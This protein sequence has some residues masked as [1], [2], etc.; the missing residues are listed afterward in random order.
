MNFLIANFQ[1]HTSKKCGDLYYKGNCIRTSNQVLKVRKSADWRNFNTY[2][3]QLDAENIELPVS[4]AD[5]YF[6]LDYNCET[7]ILIY[8]TDMIGF[9]A[10]FYYISNKIFVLSDDVFELIKCLKQGLG[11]D[12]SLNLEKVKELL[13]YTT[14]FFGTTIFSDICRSKP[15]TIVTL[16]VR[17]LKY[18]EKSYDCF[19]MTGDY[20]NPKDAAKGIFHAIDKYFRTHY[21]QGTKYAIGM[22]GGLDSRV[23]AYFAVK[24]GFDLQPIFIGRKHN[25]FGMMT[26]DCKRA[27]EVNGH[28]S[29]GP[30]SYY[31][32]RKIS[33][34]NKIMFEAE[35]APTVQDNIA[36]N[37]G[38]LKGIE[39]L[40]NALIGGEAMGAL[41]D[42]TLYHMDN[43]QLASYM[44]GK[45]T[46]IPK[47]KS[48][49]WRRIGQIFPERVVKKIAGFKEEW[50]HEIL[51]EEYH[52]KLID[53]IIIWIHEQKAL[54]LDN[55]N[56]F[57][58]YFYYNLGSG[59]KYSYYA[60]FNNTNPALFTYLNPVFI[61]E[62]LL[63][64]SDFLIDK[65]V[66]RE[67]LRMLGGGCRVYGLKRLRL[68]LTAV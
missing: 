41:V 49:F 28:L 2:A 58:K 4:A 29:L 40:V 35:N 32:P 16:A 24:N 11:I 45:I 52:K 30:I 55:V 43:E 26:N 5:F 9:E 38:R 6:C 14:T 13:L 17:G 64:K 37:M 20:K 19:Q 8:Q 15:A 10:P 57:Q 21:V 53:Q 65:K 56:I 59:G 25:F 51:T 46:N 31:D 60:S 44:L 48:R 23:G 62:M 67:L 22:S 66:Q 7:G 18:S 61:K 3:K 34:K 36:Q 47:Y 33:L 54:G 12:I 42:R 63:W 1:F 39:C 50:V 27:E 68:I